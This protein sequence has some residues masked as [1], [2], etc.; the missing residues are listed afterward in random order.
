MRV[1]SAAIAPPSPRIRNA[2]AL[3]SSRFPIGVPTTYSLLRLVRPLPPEA[4]GGG[5]GGPPPRGGGALCTPPPPGGPRGEPGGTSPASGEDL[6]N[7]SP[8]SRRPDRR[9]LSSDRQSARPGAAR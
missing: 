3:T 9:S 5:L 4:R 7:P 1:S 8:A 6:L 2:R